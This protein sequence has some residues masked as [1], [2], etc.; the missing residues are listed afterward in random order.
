MSPDQ[1]TK[2]GCVYLRGVDSSSVVLYFWNLGIDIKGILDYDPKKEGKMVLDKVPYILPDKIADQFDSEKTFVIVNIES[3]HEILCLFKKL[4]IEKFYVLSEK[5]KTEI[6]AK[7]HPWVDRGRIDY[8]REKITEL[9]ETYDSLYDKQSQE[10]MLEFIRT[11]P[12]K[13]CINTRKMRFGSTAGATMVTIFFG[14]LQMGL[15]PKLYMRMKQMKICICA[16]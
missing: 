14:I 3:Y 2:M 1:D 5:E 13:N 6:R 11:E 7:P 16:W 15:W 8:Y 9:N 4:G 12:K 10:I